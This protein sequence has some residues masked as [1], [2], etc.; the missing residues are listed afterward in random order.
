MNDPYNYEQIKGMME[1]FP[2]KLLRKFANNIDPNIL[3][4]S[5]KVIIDNILAIDLE[6]DHKEQIVLIYKALKDEK[7]P[8]YS[9][10]LYVEGKDD[11]LKN[12]VESFSTFNERELKNENPEK[13]VDYTPSEEG[14]TV[15]YSYETLKL[16]IDIDDKK[17]PVKNKKVPH[18]V[19]IDVRRIIA[20]EPLSRNFKFMV[21]IKSTLPELKHFLKKYRGVY[22]ENSI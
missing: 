18:S 13:F 6:E 22:Y 9:F 8:T 2:L 11:T 4:N 10:I 3:G 20:S 16:E 15:S 14:L 19:D 17:E 5:K 21:I 1:I 12:L 7:T